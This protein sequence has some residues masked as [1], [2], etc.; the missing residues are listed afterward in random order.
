MNYLIR[1]WRAD[2]PIPYDLLLLG[3]EN[4]A[5]IEKY[6]PNSQVFVLE[7]EQKV[8]GVGVL[9]IHNLSGEIMN[10]AVAPE[11][12]RNG[13]GR[14]LLRAM[15]EA[16]EHAAVQ[17]LRIATGNS[18]ISQIALY[19][20]EGFDLIAID[21]NYFL[22]NYSEPIWENGIQCKHQLIFQKTFEKE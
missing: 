13:F 18:G 5:L 12:Q 15:S 10:I 3:D 11:Y 6:L 19:Q 7:I 2:E 20:Q 8:V 1:Q 22:R 16:A 21:R 14:A 17:Q 4:R 9:K